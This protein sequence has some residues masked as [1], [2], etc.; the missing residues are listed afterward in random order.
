MHWMNDLSLSNA[1]ELLS[2]ALDTVKFCQFIAKIGH[3]FAIA[4][5]GTD[6]FEP[7]LPSF[8]RRRFSRTEQ[9]PDCYHLIGGHSKRYAPGTALHELGLAFTQRS[10]RWF[11][12]V[13]IRLFANLGTPVYLAVVGHLNPGLTPE[14][15]LAR[16]KC[17]KSA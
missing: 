11:L 4:S 1:D 14:Q 17:P 8:I 15:V 10:G 12:S 5:L 3:A 16:S 6:M 9:Y 7:L 13:Q 2:P